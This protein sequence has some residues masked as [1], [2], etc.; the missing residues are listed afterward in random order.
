MSSAMC[1][2]VGCSV[3]YTAII[4]AVREQGQRVNLQFEAPATQPTK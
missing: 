3:A 4:K 1:S 2:S